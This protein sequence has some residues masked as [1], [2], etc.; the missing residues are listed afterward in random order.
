[1]TFREFVEKQ[2]F[3][4]YDALSKKMWQ[5]KFRQ[6]TDKFDVHFDLENDDAV[7]ERVITIP[8]KPQSEEKCTF[9]CQIR[10]GGGDWQLSSVYFR[11]ELW[12]GYAHGISRWRDPYF[13]FIP[14]KEQGNLHLI[15]KKCWL[16]PNNNDHESKE[17]PDPDEHQCWVSLKEYLTKLVEKE[18]Q[19][20]R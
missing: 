7:A 2:N 20:H 10:K 18:V 4:C 14:N 15:K 5:E 19:D 11:C 13:C 17:A 3:F 12:D 8:Q 6:A 16:S 9:H 1:M